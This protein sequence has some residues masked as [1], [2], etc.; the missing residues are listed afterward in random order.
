VREQLAA[1][2]KAKADANASLTP[3]ELM[4]SIMRNPDASLAVRADMAKAAAPYCHARLQAIEHSGTADVTVQPI[5][6]PLM[7]REVSVRVRELLTEGEAVAGLPPGKGS[8]ASRLKAIVATGELA[9]DLY[10]AIYGP[11]EN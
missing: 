6:P 11:G 1:V 2:A 10:E 5:A 7:P 9:P 4:L 8:A 3:L